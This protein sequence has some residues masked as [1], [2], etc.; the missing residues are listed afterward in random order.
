MTTPKSAGRNDAL[1]SLHADG[2]RRTVH[3]AD[4]NGPWK[5]RRQVLFAILGAIFVGVPWLRVGGRPAVLLDLPHRSFYLFGAIFTAQDAWLLLF[6]FT[7]VGFGLVVLTTVAGR[8]W[9]AGACPQTVFVEGVYRRLERWIMGPRE[10]RLRRDRETWTAAKLGRTALLWAAYLAAS[11]VIAHAVLG[12]FFPVR[13]LLTLLRAGPAA[14]PE[15]FAWTMGVTALVLFDFGW[16]REQFCVVMCPY[17]RFQSVLTDQDSKVVG[18]DAK[19]GEPRGKLHVLGNGDCVDC[20]R[21]VVV[22]PTAIDIRDGL[23][24]DCIGCTA[25]IDACDD[26]MKKVEKPAGLIRWDSQR[27]LAGDKPRSLFRPRIIGYAIAGLVGAA[28][29]GTALWTRT[30]VQISLQR[31]RGGAAVEGDTLTGVLSV[32]IMNRRGDATHCRLEPSASG[33][34]TIT[35]P[36]A[37]IEVPALGTTRTPVFVRVPRAAYHGPLPIEVAVRCGDAAAELVR[38][39]FVGP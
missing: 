34:A 26:I 19:R 18:Y 37:D 2:S 36:L 10:A 31:S 25:C 12:Y 11:I 23:Q 9:C 29:F 16:F 38:A 22:C 35:L 27:G 39:P 24:L 3:P 5:N 13:S 33:D 14:H 1:G 4:V 20:R 21:C 28:A 32:E 30:P 15:A 17:G 6:L 7:G 8:A